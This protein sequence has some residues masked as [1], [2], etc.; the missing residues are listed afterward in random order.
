MDEFLVYIA[1]LQFLQEQYGLQILLEDGFKLF[2]IIS[3]LGYFTQIC[4]QIIKYLV[5]IQ[6]NHSA[7]QKNHR[8]ISLIS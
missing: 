2:G 6:P 3:W 4:F 7:N 1:P 5:G 8:F